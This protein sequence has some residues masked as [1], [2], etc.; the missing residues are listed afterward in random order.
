MTGAG[1]KKML[2][3]VRCHLVDGWV[4]PTEQVHLC[5]SGFLPQVAR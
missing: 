2:A 4:C 3:W 5:H 1:T